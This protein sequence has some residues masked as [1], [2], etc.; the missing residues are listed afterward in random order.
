MSDANDLELTIVIMSGPDDGRKLRFWCADGDGEV[1]ANG[2][3]VLTLGRSD[4][5]DICL[6]YDTQISRFHA[7][8]RYHPNV[9][10][11]LEDNGSRNGTFVDRKRVEGAIRLEDGALFHIGRTWLRLEDTGR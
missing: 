2:I 11:L 7:Q 1:E 3:W 6:P 8:M 9:G 10:W 4:D 5:C